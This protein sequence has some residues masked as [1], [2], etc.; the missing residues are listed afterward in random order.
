MCSYYVFVEV[1]VVFL[2]ECDSL[3]HRA[4]FIKYGFLGDRDGV[5][6]TLRPRL[7]VPIMSLFR[8]MFFF[9]WNVIQ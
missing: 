4:M 8:W 7:C 2:I 6:A 5:W 9:Q 3:R 1:D